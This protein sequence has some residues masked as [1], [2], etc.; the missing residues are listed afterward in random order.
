MFARHRYR[1]LTVLVALAAS[2]CAAKAKAMINP[3]F[4]PI[5]LVKQATLILS[6]D[7]KQGPSKNQ[8][9]ATI[10]EVLKGKTE[11]KS[12]RLDLSKATESQHA[13]ALRNLAAAA[14]PALFFAGEFA[15]EQSGQGGEAPQSR[16][17]LHVSGQW[18]EFNG[19]QDGAW[20][21]NQIDKKS[22]GTWAGGTD[23][24]R[25]AVDYI[26]QDD[27]P[28]VPVTEG[29][30]WSSEPK[31]IA[32]LS[33][34]IRAVRPIDLAGDGRLLLFVARDQGDHLLVCDAKSRNFTDVTAAR[35]LQS[36]SQAFAWGDFD[37][38]GR[39]DLISFDGKTLSLHAQQADG[40]FRG[41]GTG[42]CPC[43]GKRVHRA[44]GAGLRNHR[45]IRP[46]GQHQLLAR[47]RL[48]RCRRQAVVLHVGGH[49]RRSEET[50]PGRAMPGGRFRRRRRRRCPRAVC[51][52]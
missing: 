13:D 47:A 2:L 34:R 14:K 36:K 48:V 49:G 25:R 41:A 6:V 32:T 37:G 8:Y 12:L 11:L 44:I 23:M 50:R 7:L 35:R 52:G 10:R 40:T 9:V 51:R 46:A 24:L 42:S 3:H 30:S 29:V 20:A 1:C 15:E 38:K 28:E 19:G 4:T 21:L 26:L 27:D 45:E 18:A 16:G 22:D 33:G 43:T 31:K 5:H 39:L 17:L